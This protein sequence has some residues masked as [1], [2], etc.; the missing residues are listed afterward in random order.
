M[1][2]EPTEDDVN[3]RVVVN[4]EE[5]YSIWPFERDIPAGW[6]ASGPT[7]PK[8]ACLEYIQ[9]VWT[10]MRPLSLRKAMA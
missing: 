8:A 7:G 4:E 9:Q 10:D 2:S 3:Y 5:Q 6:R 1:S